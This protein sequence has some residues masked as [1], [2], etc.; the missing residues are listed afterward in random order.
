MHPKKGFAGIE[1]LVGVVVLAL[2][3][4]GSL[5]HRRQAGHDQPETAFAPQ[6]VT[7]VLSI[8]LHPT[9]E[10]PREATSEVTKET[11][12]PEAT[13]EIYPTATSTP[14]QDREAAVQPTYTPVPPT[15]TPIPPTATSIPTEIPTPTPSCK[16]NINPTF[17][18]HITDMSKVNYVAPPPTMGSGPS[19]K[20]HSY[21]GTDGAKVPVYAP[22]DL[23]L[24]SGAHY[25]GGP[26]TFGF[27]VS[28]EVTVRFAH[29]TDPVDK[30]KKQ[31]PSEPKDDSRGQKL[32]PLKFSAGELIAY[33]TGT[34]QAG[35]WDF[36]VY[37]SSVSNRYA[38]DPD[39]NWS[40]VFTTAVC[41]FKYF[42]SNLKSTYTEKF[43]SE[44]LGGNPPD[45][46]SFCK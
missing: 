32:D 18:H 46:E 2:L 16:S 3:I 28:C 12:T 22:V 24:E 17:T 45:G 29:I 11:P 44:I 21:I 38:N 9:L 37:N 7:T 14:S 13:E 25:V 26:Y 5:L 15:S 35:N 33:T 6:N 30:L 42:K 34:Q 36:G 40:S 10:G 19:L 8:S 4:G 39:W 43:D 23:T 27:K 1:V 41:P 31:L 20:T